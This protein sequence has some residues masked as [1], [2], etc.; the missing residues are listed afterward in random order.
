ME[1]LGTRKEDLLV[2]L[3]NTYNEKKEKLQGLI[4]SAAPASLSVEVEVELVEIAAKIDELS[5]PE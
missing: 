3:R 1:K 4:K 5:K 2:E